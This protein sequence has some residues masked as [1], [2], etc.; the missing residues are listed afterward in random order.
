MRNPSPSSG[1]GVMGKRKVT[2][3]RYYWDA[4]VFLS[5]LEDDP[6]RVS[7]IESMLSKA[8]EGK[9]HLLTSMLS[10]TE[11]AYTSYEK[12]RRVL[13]PDEEERIEALWQSP[14]M[15]VEFH[16]GIATEARTLIRDSFE[17]DGPTLKPADAI[18]AATASIHRADAFHTY[19]AKL[20]KGLTAV[21]SIHVGPPLTDQLAM[22]LSE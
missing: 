13:R 1:A 20:T 17:G 9:I 8:A 15:L 4:C 14:V 11:V 21:L 12:Q 5:Y 19:D 2:V 22:G 10:V 6:D 16:R 18:H 3:P 7:H